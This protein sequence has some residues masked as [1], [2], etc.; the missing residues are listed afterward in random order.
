M[1]NMFQ[2]VKDR[3]DR[4]FRP[5]RPWPFSE[6]QDGFFYHSMDFPDGTSVSGHWDIRGRFDSY[7]GHYPIAG[8][9][10]LD[11]GTATGFLAFSAERA[12]ARVTA[13][14][15]KNAAEF[16][17]IPHQDSLY[18]RDR[19]KW[20]SDYEV[21][22][23]RPLKKAFWHCW[24]KLNSSVEVIYAPLDELYLWHGKFDVIFAGAIIEHLSDPVSAIGALAR[25]AN[26]AVIIASTN[27]LDTD[28]WVMR[29]SHDI[30]DPAVD[31]EW[32]K[33]SSGLYRQIFDNLG[34]TLSIVESTAIY[35][36]TGTENEAHPRPTLIAHRRGLGQNQSESCSTVSAVFRPRF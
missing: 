8:K 10:V 18:H 22:H 11:V 36:P 21:A 6:C 29:P 16:R 35:S 5:E 24:H 15:T 23:V 20:I 34:F 32:W 31:F 12:G 9:T 1:K 13:L 30:A 33:L 19:A 4:R 27:I 3:S 14:D 17:R 28:E 25:L 26:E 2:W 7:I